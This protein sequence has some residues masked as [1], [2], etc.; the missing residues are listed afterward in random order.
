MTANNLAVTVIDTRVK[1]NGADI[2]NT[3]A[4]RIVGNCLKKRGKIS[5]WKF[6][7]L[8]GIK[9]E[10]TGNLA[11]IGVTTLICND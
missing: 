7:R 3:F 5:I 11:T 4:I 1:N 10:K 2:K 8:G 6:S 9:I